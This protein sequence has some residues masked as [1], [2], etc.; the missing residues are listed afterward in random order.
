MKVSGNPGQSYNSLNFEQ[1]FGAMLHTEANTVGLS[2]TVTTCVFLFHGIHV[3]PFSYS[4]HPRVYS[5]VC[6]SYSVAAI[7]LGFPTELN[8]CTS[9]PK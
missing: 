6:L 7:T 1:H 8:T 3:F 2:N 5:H 9:Y 4:Y